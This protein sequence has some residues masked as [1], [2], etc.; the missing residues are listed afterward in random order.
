MP[1]HPRT[2][3]RDRCV[4]SRWSR[5]VGS[6]PHA[7]TGRP[8][9]SADARRR[10][11]HPRTRG[12]DSARSFTDHLRG[13]SPPHAG[14]GLLRLLWRTDPRRI[15]PARGDGTRRAGRRRWSRTDHPRTRGRDPDLLSPPPGPRGSPPHAGTGHRGR[16]RPVP[17]RRITPARGDGTGRW[18]SERGAR[19]DHPRT[20][21]RDTATTGRAACFPGSPPHAGTGLHVEVDRRGGARITP[22]RG[23]GTRCRRR[24]ARVWRDHPRTRGRDPQQVVGPGVVG[25][26][27]PHAGTGQDQRLDPGHRRRITP[28]RGDGTPC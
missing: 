26:S 28:A 5:V 14:T 18:P 8:W 24:W 2:R 27:P 11:D 3:G 9:R 16:R 19:G 15:T 13:G 22:A 10:G 4:L 1:D 21:G 20:R 23:D 25:G 17:D 12:R 6:P 7:G